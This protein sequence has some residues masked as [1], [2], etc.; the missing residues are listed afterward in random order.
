MFRAQSGE[1]GRAINRQFFAAA[2]PAACGGGNAGTT[3]D[4]HD[5][6]ALNNFSLLEAELRP[7]VKVKSGHI[8]PRRD[9]AST[10]VSTRVVADCEDL[11]L[12]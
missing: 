8:F 11:S 1:T 7:F 6:P 2:A 12:L 4:P 3:S 5:L 9:E 10:R